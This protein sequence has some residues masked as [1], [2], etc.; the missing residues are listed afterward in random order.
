MT[1]L[2]FEHPEVR[3][4]RDPLGKDN[5]FCAGANIGALAKASHAHKVNFCKFTN[6]TRLAIEDASAH[7]GQRY[8]AALNGT[9]AGGGYE[10]ALACD[11]IM[12]VDDR[13]SAVSL[14]EVALLGGLARH[15]RADP[16][17]RQAQGASRPGR[18]VLRRPRKACAA[19]ARST[20]GWSMKWCRRRL[21]RRRCA[22]ARWRWPRGSDRPRMRRA[23]R[24]PPLDRRIAEN[25]RSPIAHPGRARPCRAACR[26]S[27][28]LGRTQVPPKLAEH[29]RRRGRVLAAGDGARAGRRDPASALQRAGTRHRRVPLRGRP[30]FGRRGRPAAAKGNAGDWFV[31]EIRLLLRARLQAHRRDRA[32]PVRA[33]RAGQLLSPGFSP[34]WFS[35]RIAPL[36]SPEPVP[37]TTRR[38]DAYPVAAAISGPIQWATG[39]AGADPVSRRTGAC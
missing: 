20:G 26:R 13:R 24:L 12:L 35:P 1:R 5:V 15:R 28:C 22:S 29:P 4:R 6:E 11:H 10:L 32:Q 8:L 33:D 30:G 36:C 18:C 16:A 39:S 2:R 31:R 34:N 21:G 9:A 27:P 14:P 3:A 25:E 38:R 7:S 37:A 17:D 23:S 19:D